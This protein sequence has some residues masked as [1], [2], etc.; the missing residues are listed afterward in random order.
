M[1]RGDAVTAEPPGAGPARARWWERLAQRDGG[2]AL[3]VL[4]L[5]LAAALYAPVV[6]YGLTT[7]D[8]PWLVRD[9]WIVNDPSW[10]SLRAILFD[11]DRDTRFVLGAEYLPVRDLSIM[12]DRIAW[13][14][15]YG[16]Y[17]LTSLVLYLGAIACWFAAITAFGVDRR[18][19]GLMALIWALHPTHAESVAWLAERKGLLGALF[20]GLCA[21][22]YARFRAGARPRW[23]VLAAAAAVAAVWSKAPAAFAIAAL[24]GLELALPARRASWRRSLTGLAVIAAL[25]IAA[26]VPVVIAATEAEVVGGGD[27]APA[28]WLA[29]ALGIH[30]F[31]LRLAAMALP[32]AVT[33]PI[34]TAGPSAAEIALGALGLV[35]VIATAI[36]PARGRWRPP[37]ELRAA[38]ILW[39][40]CWFPVSRLVLPLTNVLVADR[41]LLLPT[42]G[43]AL[44]VAVGIVRIPRAG[45][46]RGLIAAL[47]I[48]ASLRT[49]DARSSWRSEQTLWARAVAS[50]PGDQDAWSMRVEA[51]ANAGEIEAAFEVLEDGLARERWPRLLLRKATLLVRFGT[52]DD[53]F[54]AM[55]EA[56]EAGEPR[57]MSNVGLLLLERG[58]LPEA[59]RWARR[60]AEGTPM[61]AHAHRSHGKVALA[62]R[63]LAEAF[64]AFE[65]AV[66]LEPSPTNRYN[67]GLALAQLGRHGEARL[68]F[69]ACLGDPEIAPLARQQLARNVP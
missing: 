36:V 5:V 54:T 30:G 17:H 31:Y 57:A 18:V 3:L 34:A 2:L 27:R 64:A 60:G 55:R 53:A 56:A 33:Y 26:F 4:A 28:S 20:A 63:E 42:L 52:R 68:Q 14:D 7:Y 29:M 66:V 10:A 40:A 61:L 58:D 13:G 48:A 15:W 9:N 19:A 45:L 59:L 47:A 21:L 25:G 1:L 6:G 16:G 35:I 67:L 38:A 44:A 24:A 49:L 62:A 37:G 8:D 32:S 22:G 69:E 43:L 51:L 11:L 65:R 23:L 41:Y 50:N 39:L 46:R 12:L